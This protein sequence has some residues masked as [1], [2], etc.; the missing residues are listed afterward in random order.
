[1]T[2]SS[3]DLEELVSRSKVYDVLTRYCRRSTDATWS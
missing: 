3:A 2:V 1:M